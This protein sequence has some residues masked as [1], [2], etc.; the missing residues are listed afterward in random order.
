MNDLSESLEALLPLLRCPLCHSC[1][2]LQVESGSA[3]GSALIPWIQLCDTRLLCSSCNAAYPITEDHIPIMWDE[4]LR[5][6]YTDADSSDTEAQFRTSR[7]T[8]DANLAIYDSISDSY[9][10]WSRRSLQNAARIRNAANRILAVRRGASASSE[11]GDE[12]TR[13]FHLDFGCGPGH[14][15]GW[16]KDFGFLQIGIDVSLRNL[17][18]ARAQTGCLVVCGNAC[19]MPFADASM[20]IITESSVLHHILDWRGAIA[21]SIRICKHVGGIVVDSEPSKEEMAW[22][23]LAVSVFKAR[24][25]IY[26]ALSYF[27][28]DKYIFRNTNQAKLNLQAEVHHQPGTGFPLD[29]LEA[30]FSNAGFDA[31]II[32]SPTPEL[33]SRSRPNWKFIVLNILSARNPWNPHYGAFTAVA[34]RK[35]TD[36]SQ[37]VVPR[38]KVNP[39]PWEST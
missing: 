4:T 36:A 12:R 24:F 14:V 28:R 35:R 10:L 33:A 17:R 8:L 3:K 27:R 2:T 22:S 16:L 39:K 26:K 13:L 25:P 15:I 20:D 31:D 23:P 9:N 19:N 38:A 1:T 21:E 5:R 30:L 11:A 29:E 34:S 18:N 6:T 7:S 32:L 37:P